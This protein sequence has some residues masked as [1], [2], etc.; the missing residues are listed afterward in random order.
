MTETEAVESLIGRLYVKRH[1]IDGA[2]EEAKR[3]LETSHENDR[4]T[5]KPKAPAVR[6]APA[7]AMRRQKSE[8]ATPSSERDDSILTALRRSGGVARAKELRKSFT[9]DPSMTDIQQGAAFRNALQRLKKSG[10]IGRTGDT[11]S[12]VE[13]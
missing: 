1:A 9:G 2:I 3:L 5:R 13:A 12:L 8:P 11:W 10:R 4:A 6:E 7:K